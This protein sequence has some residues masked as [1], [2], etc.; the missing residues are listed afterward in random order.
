MKTGNVFDAPIP[1][2]N[3]TKDTRGY[4]W[5]RPPQYTAFDD[6]YEYFAEEVLSD[7]KKLNA[8]AF[9]VENGLS[10][11]G[12]TQTLMIQ[13]VGA[14][15]ISPDM[16][17][18][19]AGPVYKTLGKL[20]DSIGVEY[21]TG[22]DSQETIREFANNL[23]TVSPTKK[24]H[25]LTKAQEAEMERLN[26]EVQM[27]PPEGGLMGLGGPTDTVDIPTEPTN[28]GLVPEMKEG[29]EA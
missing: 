9:M 10:L 12:I 20:L 14:G 5:H 26:E 8:H 29:E 4:S 11:V 24:A 19:L 18:M 7:P 25:K 6:A 22:F 28:A 27:L 1:G 21:L 17:L 3:L 16:T 13:A 15:K 23:K 2:E